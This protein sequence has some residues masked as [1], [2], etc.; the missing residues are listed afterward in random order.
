MKKFVHGQPELNKQVNLNEIII[1]IP[2][3]DHLLSEIFF[4]K[5]TCLNHQYRPFPSGQIRNR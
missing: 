5:R 2:E 3:I 1:E 4:L